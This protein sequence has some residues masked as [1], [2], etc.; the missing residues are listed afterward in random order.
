M[1]VDPESYR[2]AIGQFATGVAVVTA[3]HGGRQHGMAI[4]SITSVSL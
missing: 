3:A 2:E 1:Q 4:G